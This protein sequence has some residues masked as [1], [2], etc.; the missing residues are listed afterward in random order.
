L[1]LL[2]AE[3]EKE[4]ADVFGEMEGSQ[5]VLTDAINKNGRTVVFLLEGEGELL[6]QPDVGAGPV[7]FE[8]VGLDERR[9]GGRQR[10]A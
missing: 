7:E 4:V 5:V 9:G 3:R 10:K 8:V 1:C 6:V 2:A